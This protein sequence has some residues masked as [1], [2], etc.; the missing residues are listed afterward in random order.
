[1]KR[2]QRRDWRAGEQAEQHYL[3]EPRSLAGGGDVRHIFE[4]LRACGWQDKS[5]RSGPLA[6]VSPDRSIRVGYDPFVQPGGWTIHSKA[7]AHQDEW[8]AMLGRQAP[9]EIVAGLTDAL[10]RPRSAHAPDVW[11]PLQEQR[12]ETRRP[13]GQFNARSPEGTAWMQFYEDPSGQ[14]MWWSGANDQQG[15]GWTA[16]FTASTPMHVVQAFSTALA[17]PEPVMRPR[18]RVP[19]SSKIR[20]TSVSVFP[21]QLSAWQQTRI[22]AARTATWARWAANRPRTATRPAAGSHHVRARR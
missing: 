15:N 8:I 12:W 7:G 6:F 5:K 22:Q 1:M 20:T 9:V 21:S 11:A 18:G 4:Y 3:V 16:V 2:N 19:H 10:A 17:S 13:S 14:A